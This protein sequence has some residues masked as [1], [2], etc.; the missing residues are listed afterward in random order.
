MVGMGEKP[1]RKL[2]PHWGQMGNTMRFGGAVLLVLS[3][4]QVAPPEVGFFGI[5][6]VLIG[7]V[8]ATVSE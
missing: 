8:V 2:P 5:A 6:A 1:R 4:L 7:H 3:W